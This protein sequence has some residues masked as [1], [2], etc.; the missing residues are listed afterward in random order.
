MKI[1]CINTDNTMEEIDIDTSFEDYIVSINIDG[2][3]LLYYWNYGNKIVKCYGLYVDNY[4]NI[5][6]H[7]LPPNGISSILEEN[8]D[9]IILSDKIYIVAFDTN[10]KLVNYYISD[11][12]DFYYVMNEQNSFENDEPDEEYDN[13]T[14]IKSSVYKKIDVLNTIHDNNNILDYDRNTY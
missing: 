5:N 12:G 2:I 6:S 9:N 8:S 10:N 13:T 14:E 1:L 7:S 11:Y 4:S 3:Q